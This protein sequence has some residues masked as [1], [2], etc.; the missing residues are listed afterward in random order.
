[1]LASTANP[2]TSTKMT[3]LIMKNGNNN[4]K[5][6]NEFEGN[7]SRPVIKKTDQSMYIDPQSRMNEERSMYNHKGNI[8]VVQEEMQMKQMIRE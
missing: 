6:E 4:N 2:Y 3:N 8:F 1:M 7:F 5:H